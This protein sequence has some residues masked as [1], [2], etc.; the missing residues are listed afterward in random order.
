MK[1]LFSPAGIIIVLILVAIFFLPKRLPD[2]AKK[3]R[4]P[5]R[6]FPDEPDSTERSSDPHDS[7]GDKEEDGA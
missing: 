6:A 1:F 2:A 3:L 5:M 7:D 4:K